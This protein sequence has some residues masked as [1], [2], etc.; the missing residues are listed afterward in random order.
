[1]EKQKV[2]LHV[3]DKDNVATIFANDVTD[4]SEVTILD[5]SGKTETV[6]IKGDVPYGHKIAV[7]PIAKGELIIK[8]GEEIGIATSDIAKGEYVHIHNLD[9]LRGRG[10]L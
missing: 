4:K 5:K 8:Y 2:A 6:T 10:D 3:N 9:S 7:R 1:M